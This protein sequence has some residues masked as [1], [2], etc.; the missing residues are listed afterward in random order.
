MTIIGKSRIEWAKFLL[1]LA[2]T[3]ILAGIT[4]IFYCLTRILRY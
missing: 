1:A 4:T 2:S 3:V